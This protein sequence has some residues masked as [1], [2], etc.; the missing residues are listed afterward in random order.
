MT[1]T[2]SGPSLFTS[3]LSWARAKF[4]SL[5]CSQG[6][7]AGRRR[8]SKSR[9]LSKVGAA[10][11][12]FLAAKEAAAA[13]RSRQVRALGVR[14]RAQEAGPQLPSSQPRG[15]C[16]AH[17]LRQHHQVREVAVSLPQRTGPCGCCGTASYPLL[18]SWENHLTTKVFV[19]R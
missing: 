7:T 9:V 15:C 16:R 6:K 5:C 17:P 19:N 18:S 14:G 12:H 3:H 13:T 4:V 8:T 2:T 1:T 10:V 11:W